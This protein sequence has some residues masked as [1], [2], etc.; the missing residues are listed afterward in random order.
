MVWGKMSEI[1]ERKMDIDHDEIA[2]QTEEYGGQWGLNHTRRLLALISII[3]EGLTYNSE[4]VWIAAHLHDW[5]AYP[6]W[7]EKEV[8][9]AVRSRQVAE[10]FLTQNGCPA[11]L[12]GLVLECIE[13]HHA[14]GD[15]LN[16]ESIL[17]READILDFL[18]VVGV[19]RDFSK[20]AR[21]LR[22]AFSITQGRLK[23]LPGL[24]SLPKAKA[25]AERR[26]AEMEELLDRFEADSFGFF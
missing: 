12:K 26:A 10:A 2:R 21:D 13:F 7:A 3:G 18:G 15:Q 14:G 9:H 23:S 1:K 20:N 16:L 19:L 17:L 4:A 6:A 11:E 22:K 8:D 5:G 25:M 24:L